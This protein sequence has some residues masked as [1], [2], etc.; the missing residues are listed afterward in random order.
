MERVGCRD[1]GQSDRPTVLW[2]TVFCLRLP[3]TNLLNSNRPNATTDGQID[4]I[5]CRFIGGG[6]VNVPIL[7]QAVVD[8]DA[9]NA[10]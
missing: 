2:P 10:G 7:D 9:A 8:I 3:Q 4:A 1:R 6:L 5:G